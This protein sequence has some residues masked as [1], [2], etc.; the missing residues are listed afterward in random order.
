MIDKFKL[1]FQEEAREILVELEAALLALNE[2]PLRQG[3]CRTGVSRAAHHQ[4]LGIH[5]RI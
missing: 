3:A 4:G 5:V 1:A 2:E